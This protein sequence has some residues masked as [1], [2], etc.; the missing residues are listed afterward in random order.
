MLSNPKCQA[1]MQRVF[2]GQAWIWPYIFYRNEDSSMP[3]LL[4]LLETFKFH[5]EWCSTHAGYTFRRMLKLFKPYKSLGN[6]WNGSAY[7]LA[8]YHLYPIVLRDE[9]MLPGSRVRNGVGKVN[10]KNVTTCDNELSTNTYGQLLVPHFMHGYTSRGFCEITIGVF[11]KS[12]IRLTWRA[13][14]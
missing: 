3:L 4:G 11:D 14:N 7:P 5:K 6:D 2:I 12:P 1:C 9:Q 8:L 13:A 10:K